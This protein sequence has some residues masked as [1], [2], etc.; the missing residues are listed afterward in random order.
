[1]S[2]FLYPL[3]KVTKMHGKKIRHDPRTTLLDGSRHISVRKATGNGLSES[4]EATR[5]R[6]NFP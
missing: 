5:M 6:L 2:G 3:A 1:M 4:K